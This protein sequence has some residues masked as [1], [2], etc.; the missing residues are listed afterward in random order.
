VVLARSWSQEVARLDEGWVPPDPPEEPPVSE[1]VPELGREPPWSVD[2]TLGTRDTFTEPGIFEGVRLGLRG[3]HRAFTVETAL[4]VPP[5]TWI[6]LDTATVPA[7]LAPGM[8]VYRRLDT[9]TFDLLFGWSAAIAQRPRRL[10][11]G[12]MLLA[13]VET[14]SYAVQTMEGTDN[15]PSILTV[16]GGAAIGPMFGAGVE[17]SWK[18]HVGARLYVADRMGFRLQGSFRNDHAGIFSDGTAV[19]DIWVSR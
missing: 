6:G 14:R 19:F 16:G 10:A 9:A 3:R 5:S 11:A 2:V 7:W 1:P 8:L 4:F 12:P 13:G 17:V 15:G 18:D